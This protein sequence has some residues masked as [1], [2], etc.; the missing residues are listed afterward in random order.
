MS[1]ALQL[2]L[3]SDP[4][5]TSRTDAEILAWLHAP[6]PQERRAPTLLTAFDVLDRFGTALGGA[7][8]DKLEVYSTAALTRSAAVRWILP[9]FTTTGVDFGHPKILALLRALQNDGV[10][11]AGELAAAETA[12]PVLTR[13][14][15]AG[16]SR[17][18]PGNVQRWRLGGI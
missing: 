3:D 13:W 12:A 14:E 2:L 1:R 17:P 8:L 15:A 4:A 16:A 10:L 6:N 5:N 11:S 18:T 7:F 9:F